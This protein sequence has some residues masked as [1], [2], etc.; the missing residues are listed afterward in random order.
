MANLFELL[1]NTE[2]KIKKN[3]SVLVARLMNNASNALEDI[4]AGYGENVSTSFAPSNLKDTETQNKGFMHRLGEGLGTATRMLDNPLVRGGI[5][6]GLARAY[7]DNNP[8]AQG[9]TATIATQ[10]NKTRDNLYRNALKENYGYTDNDLQGI[11]GFITDNT[12]KNLTDSAYK[13]RKLKQVQSLAEM[14]DATSRAKMIGQWL[15]NGEITPEE[16]NS[17]IK[18]YIDNADFKNSNVTRK[19]NAQIEW[20]ET[21]ADALKNPPT[22]KS[23]VTYNINRTENVIPQKQANNGVPFGTGNGT[24]K[25]K[26]RNPQNGRVYWVDADKVEKYIQDGGEVVK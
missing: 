20:L 23:E 14:K 26:V 18:V 24:A 16:A 25:V 11:T 22:K 15:N 6:Y 4:G 5:A 8:L 1:T 9:L 12:Y 3:P 21:R 7:G 10:Q 13:T 2:N 19:T 17:L